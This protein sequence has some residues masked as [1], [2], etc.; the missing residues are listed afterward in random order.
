MGVKYYRVG[1][2]HSKFNIDPVESIFYDYWVGGG[3][4]SAVLGLW[5]VFDDTKVIVRFPAVAKLCPMRQVAWSDFEPTRLPVQWAPGPLFCGQSTH[6]VDH[7]ICH[8][9]T[10]PSPPHKSATRAEEHPEEKNTAKF[11]YVRYRGDRVRTNTRE[12]LSQRFCW[13]EGTRCGNYK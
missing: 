5:H 2:R 4:G 12:R 10:S 13:I 9:P 11:G 6:S 1:W 7:K 3:R 8:S